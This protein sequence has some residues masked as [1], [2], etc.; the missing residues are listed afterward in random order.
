MTTQ[1]TPI[2]HPTS[3]QPPTRHETGLW[4]GIL[5]LTALSI[6]TGLPALAQDDAQETVD[7]QEAVEESADAS[8]HDPDSG[9]QAAPPQAPPRCD[10]EDHAA[11]D[12]WVGEWEVYRWRDEWDP[13]AWREQNPDKQPATNRIRKIHD[14]CALHE[15]YSA[16]RGYEGSSVNFYDRADGRWHQTWIDSTGT[17]LYLAGGME[18][19]TMVLADDPPEGRPHSRISW[20]PQEDGS[21]RQTWE[22]STDGETW[23]VVFDGRYVRRGGSE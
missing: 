17:P 23:K 4:T 7:P 1:E 13:A 19:D 3:T 9:E 18:G 8:S 16:P 12:F 10:T 11:F 5:L 21:V 15:E 20:Q 22:Q 2:L 6:F 14:G